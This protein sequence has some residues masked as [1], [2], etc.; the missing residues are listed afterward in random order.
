MRDKQIDE[1]IV[2]TKPQVRV[3]LSHLKKACQIA[4]NLE[5][6]NPNIYFT[7]CENTESVY[8]NPEEFGRFIKEL[9]E[10]VK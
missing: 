6:Y 8:T 7:C 2:L 1:S 9:E 3:L 5:L 10:K 4:R